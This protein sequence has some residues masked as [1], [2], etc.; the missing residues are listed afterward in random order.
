[1]NQSASNRS[2]L[3]RVAFGGQQEASTAPTGTQ[4]Y[5]P[6]QRS[7]AFVSAFAPRKELP[8]PVFSGW[9]LNTQKAARLSFADLMEV[10]ELRVAHVR[11]E[12]L[13]AWIRDS[14]V[15][16]PDADV[17]REQEQ[18]TKET[19]LDLNERQALFSA[20]EA[21]VEALDMMA[22]K[23]SLK[24]TAVLDGEFALVMQRFGREQVLERLAELNPQ[25]AQDYLANERVKA[26]EAKR[27]SSEEQVRAE[28]AAAAKAI[29]AE[30]VEQ[31]TAQALG[32]AQ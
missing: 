3:F 6:T 28:L 7:E 32:E 31:A 13:P 9:R 1:M 8:R 12:N 10:E 20:F 26:A 29:A 21:E 14:G 23:D 18:L 30:S 17:K 2:N 24:G 16:V 5:T 27:E 19:G 25:A 22:R 11:Y 15:A 4:G